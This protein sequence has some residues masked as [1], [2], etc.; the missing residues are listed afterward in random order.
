MPRDV[1]VIIP[2][3]GQ[4]K[5]TRQCLAGLAQ[6]EPTARV[7]V[8][9]DG[10][11]DDAAEQVE[12]LT[13]DNLTLIRSAPQGLTAAWNLGIAAA[14]TC[15]IVLLNNDVLIQ[16]PWLEQLLAPLRSGTA[17]VTG[18]RWRTERQL[19]PDVLARLPT[20]RLLEG[21]C[22][23]FSRQTW[24][25]LS[26]FTSSLH[27]YWSDTDFQCRVVREFGRSALQAVDNLPLQH[28]GHA[29][30]RHESDRHSRWRADR[31]R[32]LNLWT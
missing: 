31:G 8:V 23:A 16:E 30:T 28:L 5:L 14:T 7:I 10:S 9:D 25:R 27:L 6:H 26:G 22:L 1:T 24:E 15:W 4:A 21:W 32:F 13:S 20:T 17:H 12:Q 19:P 29:T 2:Q 11:P 18:A 3:R